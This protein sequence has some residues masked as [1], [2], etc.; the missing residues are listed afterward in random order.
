MSA[1]VRTDYWGVVAI[2]KHIVPG[3]SLS[4]AAVG[5]CV[6]ETLD[7]GVIISALQ[8]VEPGFRI[9]VVTTIP[10]R[11]HVCEGAGFGEHVAQAS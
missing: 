6:E 4:R 9:A 2:R 5:V 3:E 10:Q 8:I 1:R 11:I 7:N